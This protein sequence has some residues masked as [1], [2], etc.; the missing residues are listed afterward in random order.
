MKRE[1]ED[2]AARHSCNSIDSKLFTCQVVPLIEPR[3]LWLIVLIVLTFLDKYIKRKQRKRETAADYPKRDR[4]RLWGTQS[5]MAKNKFKKN[6]SVFRK[7]SYT[8]TTT[9][10]NI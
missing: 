3:Q 7:C 4:K 2:E 5:A 6:R 8:M 10:E 1:I 9:N